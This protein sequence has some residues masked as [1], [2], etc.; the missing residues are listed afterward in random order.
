LKSLFYENDLLTNKLANL[1]ISRCTRAAVSS[2]TTW[3]QQCIIIM[4]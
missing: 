1:L 2:M 3:W 4:I